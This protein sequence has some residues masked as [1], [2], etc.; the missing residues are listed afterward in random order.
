M[1]ADNKTVARKGIYNIN[2]IKMDGEWES[3]PKG[4][5]VVDGKKKVKN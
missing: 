2:G 4:V 3:M 1:T 5:Y